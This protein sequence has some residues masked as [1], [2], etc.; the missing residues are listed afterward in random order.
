MTFIILNV[1]MTAIIL[2]VNDA[3]AWGLPC[4][5]YRR[6]AAVQTTRRLVGVDGGRTTKML[7]FQH[8]WIVTLPKF[9]SWHHPLGRAGG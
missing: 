3:T 4:N 5:R 8:F 2:N 7:H 1:K 6:L 9:N